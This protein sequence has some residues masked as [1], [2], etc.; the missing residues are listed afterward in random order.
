MNVM[1]KGLADIASS[2]FDG[3]RLVAE[4]IE[5]KTK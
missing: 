2:V 3:L 4:A 5:R 1:E